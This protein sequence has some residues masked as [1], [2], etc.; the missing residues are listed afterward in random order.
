MAN[1][2]SK[3]TAGSATM[4]IPIATT[5]APGIAKFNT[6]DFMVATDGTVTSKQKLGAVQFIFNVLPVIQSTSTGYQ[7]QW[8][9]NTQYPGVNVTT[10]IKDIREILT[11]MVI[12]YTGPDDNE[13]DLRSGN[14]YKITQIQNTGATS[15]YLFSTSDA[16]YIGT[17]RGDPGEKGDGLP[18]GGT[19]GQ[20][21]KKTADGTAWGDIARDV[22]IVSQDYVSWVLPLINLDS[23]GESKIVSGRLVLW[24]S[25]G[26][27][28]PSFLDISAYQW[29][30]G[31]SGNIKDGTIVI[32]SSMLGGINVRGVKFSYNNQWWLGLD[33]TVNGASVNSAKFNGIAVNAFDLGWN[34]IPYKNNNTDEVLNSEINTNIAQKAAVNE[35]SHPVNSLYTSIGATEPAALFGGTWER[36]KDVFLLS[37]G[38]MYP[39]GSTGGEATHELTVN[40][41]AEHDH[42][43]RLANSN[44]DFN[45]ILHHEGGTG[46]A[47]G[48]QVT[49][50]V[51]YFEDGTGYVMTVTSG[52]NQPHN[53]M[54]PYLTVYVWKR[55]A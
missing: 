37:A 46:T 16:G 41:L 35:Q 6:N 45:A 28:D 1:Q 52:G 20:I 44:Y 55:I 50:N 48:T 19:A 27:F 10:L 49:Q 31:E 13:H 32:E 40:E 14:L 23:E 30:K 7:Y 25:T 34:G 42:M 43:Q 18:A 39:A 22:N 17:L 3:I 54:P 15:V 8:S 12:L 26:V 38:D 11:D 21:V 9:Y 5:E 53:N 51:E 29:Y 24:R 36:I 2:V 4:Q 47:R 33:F